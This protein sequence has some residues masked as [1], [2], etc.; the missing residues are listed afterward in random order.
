MLPNELVS[1]L[2]QYALSVEIQNGGK[3]IEIYRYV[4]VER[5]STNG[6][7]P[8][9]SV[10]AFSLNLMNYIQGTFPLGELGS[11]SSD[12]R[13]DEVRDFFRSRGY[14]NGDEIEA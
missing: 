1:A 9:I 6:H 12:E 2:K 3:G 11:A 8:G 13:M 7:G 10:A 14:V 5:T 4:K